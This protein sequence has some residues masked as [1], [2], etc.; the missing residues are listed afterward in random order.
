MDFATRNWFGYINENIRLDEGLRDIGL[1]EFVVDAIEAS[2]ADAP[3]RAKT[4]LGHMWKKTHLHQFVRPSNRIQEFRF[5]TMEPLL[6]ALDYWTEFAKQEDLDPPEP[7]VQF[8][9]ILKEGEN[10]TTEKAKRT[11]FVLQN[12]NRT[13]KDDALGKW[14]K[15]FEK[16][17]KALSKLGLNS[18]TV[19]FVQET[20]NLAITKAWLGFSSRFSDTLVFLNMHPDNIRILDQYQN[21]VDADNK[22]MANISLLEICNNYFLAFLCI[23]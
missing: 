3:E 22:A 4:W 20:L 17:V 7:E 13:I 9:S 19:E 5:N 18:K 11:R 14:R 2:I 21:M 23:I 15:A 6:S 10:W 12:I 8:E 16:A 1:S